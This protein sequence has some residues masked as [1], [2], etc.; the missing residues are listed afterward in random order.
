MKNPTKQIVLTAKGTISK[1]ISNAINNCTFDKNKVY[2][3]SYSGSG[4]FV[5]KKDFTGTII[6]ILN[7]QGY[8]FEIRATD[9]PAIE[10]IKIPIFHFLLYFSAHYNLEKR[11]VQFLFSHFHPI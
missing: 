3:V 7:A 9:A 10:R 11:K 5:S 4:R 1:N 2:P 8:K 6:S